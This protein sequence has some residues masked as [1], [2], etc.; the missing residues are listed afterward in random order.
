[1]KKW[2]RCAMSSNIRAMA[3]IL[4]VEI[5]IERVK[6][7]ILEAIKEEWHSIKEY[8]FEVFNAKDNFGKY[9]RCRY[10]IN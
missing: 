9:V 4:P 3:N 10:N 2:D 6:Q 1:M 7:E 8:E 5:Q